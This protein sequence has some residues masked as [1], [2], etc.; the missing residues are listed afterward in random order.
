MNTLADARVVLESALSRLRD[1]DEALKENIETT[2][3]RIES[4]RLKALKALVNP[5][6]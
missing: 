3:K 2:L 4:S 1:G 6:S 5:D